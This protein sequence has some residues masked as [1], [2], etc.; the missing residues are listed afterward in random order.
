MPDVEDVLYKWF[1]EVGGRSIP[2]SMPASMARRLAFLLGHEYFN[3]GI[4]WLHPF[5]E[6][7]NIKFRKLVSEA[8]VVADDAKTEE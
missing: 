6:T 1:E 8:A 7:H 5:N 2:V 4:G 3:P